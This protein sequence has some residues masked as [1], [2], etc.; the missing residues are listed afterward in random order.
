M[1]SMEQL[2]AIAA[3]VL[4]DLAPGA[5]LARR[6]LFLARVMSAGN[7][8]ENRMVEEHFGKSALRDVLGRPPDKIFDRESWSFWHNVFG[9]KLREMPDSFFT[10]YPWFKDR[11]SGKRPITAEML[12]NFPDC[13]GPV[14]SC[15]E[16]MAR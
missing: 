8:E 1:A 9:L 6:D 10:V 12:A 13:N 14:H 4:P 15:D 5:A 7:W 11:K 3:R 2:K 16:L